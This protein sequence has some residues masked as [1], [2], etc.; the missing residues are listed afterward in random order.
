MQGLILGIWLFQGLLMFYDE[1]YFHR[2]RGLG[3][4]ESIGHPVDSLFF[5]LPFLGA[6]YQADP[7]IFIGLCAVSCLI[8]TKDEFVHQEECEGKEQWLHSLLFV[9]HPIALFGLWEAWHSGYH[10]IIQMQTGIIF[11]FMLYQIIYW[12]FYR[13]LKNESKTASQ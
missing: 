6:Q 11:L 8:I 10:R 9:I 13:T 7:Q 4:W 1:F 12:N 2:K 5:L 3:K